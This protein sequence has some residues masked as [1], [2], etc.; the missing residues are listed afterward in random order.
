MQVRDVSPT[1][2]SL[3]PFLFV[4]ALPNRVCLSKQLSED[5][6]LKTV[7]TCVLTNNSEFKPIPLVLRASPMDPYKSDF[8]DHPAR[9]AGLPPSQVDRLINKVTLFFATAAIAAL[10]IFEQPGL[11]V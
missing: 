10:A 3:Q 2:Y 7:S 8:G 5:R 1:I 4:T 6:K 9:L 11:D